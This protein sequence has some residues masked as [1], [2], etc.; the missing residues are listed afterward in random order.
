MGG[1][2]QPSNNFAMDDC[3]STQLPPTLFQP[4][5]AHCSANMGAPAYWVSVKVQMASLYGC[6]M[7]RQGM[8]TNAKKMCLFSS[9]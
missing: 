4:L 3:N 1:M 8:I 7:I 2:G 9:F 5:V 6:V